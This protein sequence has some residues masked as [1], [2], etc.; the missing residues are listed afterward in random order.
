MLSLAGCT[1]GT[2]INE[3]PML[4]ISNNTS[5]SHD[6]TG[7]HERLETY[8]TAQSTVGE[9]I[10][11]P[12]FGDFGQLLFPVDRNVSSSMTLVQVSTSNVYL[13]YPYI[14]VDKTVEI[15]N[16]LRSEAVEEHQIFHSIYSAEEIARNPSKADT[17]IFV[18][19]GEPG[20]PFAI[21][22]AG[23]GF[24]YVGIFS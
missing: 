20:K 19:R 11:D 7:S 14:Q 2:T 1:S 6:T 24:D 9:V 21:T 8:F 3:E 12:K 10:N 4:P 18:F 23:G 22:N 13:W 15:L 17:G 5:N 16:Y